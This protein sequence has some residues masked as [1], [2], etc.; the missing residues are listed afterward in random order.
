M[1]TWS[2]FWAGIFFVYQIRFLNF[3]AVI[4]SILPRIVF[5]NWG[6]IQLI[7][8]LSCFKIWIIFWKLVIVAKCEL[9]SMLW[10]IK[11]VS[12]KGF[13]FVMNFLNASAPDF[14]E[15]VVAIDAVR[16]TQWILKSSLSINWLSFT[17]WNNQLLLVE[18][19]GSDPAHWISVFEGLKCSNC[20]TWWAV[21]RKVFK[22]L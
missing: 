22:S 4:S 3:L 15:L 14:D 16:I 17:S 2:R 6:M 12:V 5:S 8:T 7:V 18:C 10:I 21:N 13:A 20:L 11:I 1:V 19:C 9:R